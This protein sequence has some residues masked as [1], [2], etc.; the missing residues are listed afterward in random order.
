MQH[1]AAVPRVAHNTNHDPPSG[2]LYKQIPD[3]DPVHVIDPF[4]NRVGVGCR[5]IL[6]VDDRPT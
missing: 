1:R 4:A 3:L 5:A 6:A 2:A